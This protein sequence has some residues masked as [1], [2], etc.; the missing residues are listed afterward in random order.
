MCFSA[1][2]SFTASGLLIPTGIYCLKEAMASDKSYLPISSWP[3]FFGIQQT[4]E[5][6]LWLGIE[7][8]QLNLIQTASLGFLFFSHFFWLF[9]TPFSAFSLET[10]KRLR[11]FLMIFTLASFFFGAL[12][13]FPLFI[14]KSL[15][16]IKV[17]NGSI[18]YVTRFIFGDLVP[19]H[20]TVVVYAI[21]ILVPL[22]IS[23]NQKVNFLGSLIFFSAIASY[24]FFSHAFISVWCFFA[25]IL[26]FYL[27]YAIRQVARLNS[28]PINSLP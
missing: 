13:Y 22:L 10:N 5:G 6:F 16:S 7:H 2:A 28:E 17:V 14:D 15:L 21:I 11:I 3:L 20:F 8:N 23:S 26:S 1:S 25:A 18:Y 12:L 9:W 27:L 19:K 24:I 4:I